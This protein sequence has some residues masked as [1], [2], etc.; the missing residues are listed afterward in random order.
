M[1]VVK[2]AAAVIEDETGRILVARRGPGGRLAGRWE[3]PGGKLEPGEDAPDALR[4]EILEE[5]G[6]EIRVGEFLLAVPHESPEQAI[7]LL[8]YRASRLGGALRL[9]DHDA[10]RWT[11]PGELTGLDLAEPD[12]VIAGR[13]AAGG[14]PPG[15]REEEP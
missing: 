14:R 15:A 10:V 11:A 8:A 1:D 13:L 12:K 9:T 7:V 4:R 3:F 5:L 6:L 2:V